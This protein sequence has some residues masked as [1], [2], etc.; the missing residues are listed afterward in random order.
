MTKAIVTGAMGVAL[1]TLSVWMHIKGK[2]GSGWGFVA[3][4][5]IITSCSSA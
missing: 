4:C 5:L 1:A 2:D 3:V